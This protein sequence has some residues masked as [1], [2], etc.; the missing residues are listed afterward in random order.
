MTPPRYPNCPCAI[1]DKPTGD[2]R[3]HYTYVCTCT[4]EAASKRAGFASS[5]A[6]ALAHCKNDHPAPDYSWPYGE[7]FPLVEEP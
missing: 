2:C 3:K 5:F 1:A 7:A 4:S 6:Q